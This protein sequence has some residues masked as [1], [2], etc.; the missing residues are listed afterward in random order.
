MKMMEME[1]L[2]TNFFWYFQVKEIHKSNTR[3]L[4]ITHRNV[5][6]TLQGHTARKIE[7][8]KKQQKSR[9]RTML[10]NNKDNYK[11]NNMSSVEKCTL[12]W[13]RA[14]KNTL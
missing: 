5:M 2:R 9:L 13:Y 6:K 11:N 7:K 4:W 12:K 3:N 8:R 10:E 14:P 1:S